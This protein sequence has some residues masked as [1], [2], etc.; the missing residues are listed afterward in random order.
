MTLLTKNNLDE[1]KH[2]LKDF[3]KNPNNYKTDDDNVNNKLWTARYGVKSAINSE[4]GNILPLPFRMCAFVPVNVPICFGL[5]CLPAT[6]YNIILFNFINQSYNAGMNY[7][8]G[9]GSKESVRQ[10]AISFCLAVSSSITT[11]LILK[12]RFEAKKITSVFGEALIRIFPSMVAGFLNLFFMR[13]DYFITG[14]TIRDDQGN[15]LG[16]SRRCG[17]KAVLE[18]AL[19]RAIIPLPLL[20]NY[21]FLKYLSKKNLS[22]K[23]SLAIEILICTV[24]LG[25]GLPLSISVFKERAKINTS[26]LEEDLKNILAESQ[27]KF[28]YYNKGL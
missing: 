9:T 6:F 25:I 10:T 18:G 27:I 5:V 14:I 2:I 22:K 13:S 21:F 28:V 1:Y 11:G 8:N 16:T 24:C 26:L 15:K 23:W 17:A 19:S 3:E 7:Y 20:F 4:T 12:K